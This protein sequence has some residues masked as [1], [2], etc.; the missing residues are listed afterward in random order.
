MKKILILILFLTTACGYQPIYF[1]KNTNDFN[2]NKIT[3]IGNKKINNNIVT[4]LN[5][6]LQNTKDSKDEVILNSN[7]NISETSKNSKGQVATYRTTIKV[8]LKIKDDNNLIKD[9]DFL[10]SFSYNNL[11]NKFDL[12][13]Y[14]K[15]IENSLTKKIIEELI[16]YL[17]L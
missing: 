14:Q 9:K 1:G 4:T 5:F 11:E 7:I 2:F 10:K 3:L 17:S 16:I 12:V 8:N 13:K 15:D 6:K